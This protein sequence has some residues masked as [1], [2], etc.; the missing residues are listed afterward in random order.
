[1]SFGNPLPRDIQVFHIQ[2]NPD[3]LRH[4]ATLCG[5]SRVANVEEWIENRQF[6]AAAVQLDAAFRELNRER[7]RMW[8]L[9]RAALDRLIRN[10]PRI[11]TATAGASLSVSP[12]RNV[13]LVRVSNADS[14]PI[15]WSVAMLRQ[16]WKTNSWL[17]GFKRDLDP[18]PEVAIWEAM[19]AAYQT[20][21]QKHTLAVD[22]RKEVFGL[23][24]V[25]S[26]ADEQTTLSGAK[27]RHLS[28]A[29][30]EE[31]VRL[32]SVTPQPVQILKK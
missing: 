14:Q 13:A 25:R 5:H 19:A 18:E 20:F 28:P 6:R 23:L 27:L 30:A 4:A 21:T 9:I 1:M 8:P 17:D 10:E 12:A 31:L 7:R 15:E 11:A 26:A 3:E 32:Y 16:M 2:F 24:L 29:E 22:A